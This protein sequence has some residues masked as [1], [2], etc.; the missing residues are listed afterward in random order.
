MTEHVN[1][2]MRR[3]IIKLLP[4]L[5]KKALESYSSFM[6]KQLSD[7]KTTD[8]SKNFKSHHDACKA[9]LAHIQL[10]IKLANWAEP[11]H[12]NTDHPDHSVL[13]TMVSKAESEIRSYDEKAG[14]GTF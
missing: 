5:L 14:Q 10:L 11:G 12:A 9:A 1:D 7:E 3:E 8:D 4:D 2:A 13:A 6:T